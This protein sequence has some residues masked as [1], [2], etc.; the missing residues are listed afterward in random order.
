M[1]SEIK[2]NS[3]IHKEVESDQM[4]PTTTSY[5][6]QN[7]MP[8]SSENKT[9]TKNP[10]AESPKL[11]TFNGNEWSSN[12]HQDMNLDKRQQTSQINEIHSKMTAPQI[13]NCD[14][15]KPGSVLEEPPLLEDLGIDL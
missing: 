6:N 3:P 2:S 9:R 14:T 13:G 15:Q 4:N 10:F 7:W 12:S 8:T 5:E 1:F 11:E